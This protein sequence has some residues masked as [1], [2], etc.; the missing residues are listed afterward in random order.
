MQFWG[1]KRSKAQQKCWGQGLDALTY[2]KALE[3][4]LTTFADKELLSTLYLDRITE[5]KMPKDEH[6]IHGIRDLVNTT[7][8]MINCLERLSVHPL[9]F[10]RMVMKSFKE[11]IP[12]NL[13]QKIVEKLYL[14]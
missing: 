4:V 3:N 5:Q 9:E 11:R 14:S 1:P 12:F 10:S 6:D 8:K 13:I 7:R 2:D